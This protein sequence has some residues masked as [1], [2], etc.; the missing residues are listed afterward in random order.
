MKG[1]LVFLLVFVL[2]V[3]I[4]FFG[5]ITLPPANWIIQEYIADVLQTDYASLVEGIINGVIYGVIVF[6]IFSTILWLNDRTKKPKET[7]VKVQET[8]TAEPSVSSAKVEEIEG[9]GTVYASK[10]KT[11]GVKTT[12]ELLNT[13]GTK[14]GRKELSEKTG[15]SETVIL[16]WVNMADLFRIKGIGEEYS[17]LLK[18]AGVSTVVELG[19]RNPENLCETLG[20]V[21]EA[22]KLVR[23]TPTL[24]QIKDWV[25]QAKSLPRM[26]EY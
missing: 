11:A 2:F 8:K 19:R 7:V 4:S 3:I 25:E 13:G 1:A 23:R 18:E 15:I 21:N 5:I 9:I 26:V 20:G 10:L 17:E 22:K 14:Q 24:N 6:V 16:E 12:Y